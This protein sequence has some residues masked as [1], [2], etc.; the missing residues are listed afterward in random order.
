MLL[1]IVKSFWDRIGLGDEPFFF[2]MAI[3]ICPIAFLV[4]AV[5][6]IVLAIKKSRRAK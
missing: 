6:S 2:I 1:S 5:G 4:G 3:L